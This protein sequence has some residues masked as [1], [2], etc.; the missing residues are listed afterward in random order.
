MGGF[1]GQGNQGRGRHVHI[2][3]A[4][5][6]WGPGPPLVMGI[7]AIHPDGLFQ[8]DKKSILEFWGKQEPILSGRSDS[9][10]TSLLSLRSFDS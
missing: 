1:E 10:G 9:L 6:V 8:E 2:R 7:D 5:G 3:V 4:G